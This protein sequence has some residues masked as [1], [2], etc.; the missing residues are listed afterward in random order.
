MMK[1]EFEK[2]A[3]CEVSTDDYA[4]IEIVYLYHPSIDIKDDIVYLY[5]LFGMVTI[6]DMLPRAEAVRQ[7]EHRAQEL[8]LEIERIKE[9]IAELSRQ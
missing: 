2:L 8:K 4:I 3:K 5:K 1:H 7:L 6:K 9:E